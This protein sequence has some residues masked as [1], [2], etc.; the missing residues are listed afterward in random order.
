MIT[1]VSLSSFKVQVQHSPSRVYRALKALLVSMGSS[2]DPHKISLIK[3]QT[4][5][6][7]MPSL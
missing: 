2:Q 7:S 3:G 1:P 4:E 5:S 6:F